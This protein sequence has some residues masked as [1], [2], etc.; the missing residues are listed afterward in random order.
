[1]SG[2]VLPTTQLRFVATGFSVVLSEIG[3][4]SVLVPPTPQ[5]DCLWGWM[6]ICGRKS[7]QVS[8]PGWS[9]AD[10]P[11]INFPISLRGSSIG[12]WSS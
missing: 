7:C 1:M 8:L 3:T 12:W 4:A 6:K 10:V 5:G 11:T 9:L 2:W